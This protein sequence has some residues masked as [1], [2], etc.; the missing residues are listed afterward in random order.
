MK[1]ELNEDEALKLAQLVYLGNWM[2]DSFKTEFNELDDNFNAVENKVYELLSKTKYKKYTTKY[3]DTI[4]E[5]KELNELVYSYITEYN[6]EVFKDELLETLVSNHMK[7]ELGTEQ[8]E[9]LTEDELYEQEIRFEN[10]I[11][12][13]LTKSGFKTLYV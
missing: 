5:S 1:L 3:N 9:N 4:E 2:R 13:K 10:K 11:L 12:K 8:Y 7:L 6:S